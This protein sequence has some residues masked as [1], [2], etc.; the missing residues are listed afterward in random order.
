M[1]RLAGESRRIA[2]HIKLSPPGANDP[3]I[4]CY[5]EGRGEE[6]PLLLIPGLG[7][8][9]W[10]WRKLVPALPTGHRTLA[11][12]PRGQGRSASPAG[13]YTVAQMAEDLARLAGEVGMERPV[14]IG[15]G[16]GARCALLLAIER[17]A[18]PAGLVL[19]GAE[20]GP[21]AGEARRA[22]TERMECARRGDMNAAYRALKAEGGLP[23][24]MSPKE[25]A[26]HHR[27][28][29]TAD[30]AGH[31][32]CCAAELGAPDLAD[33]LEEV[34]CPALAIAG[35]LDE[36]RHPEAERLAEGVPGGEAVVVAGAGRFVQ[37][38]APE[39]LHTLLEEFLRKHSLSTPGK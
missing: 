5:E 1:V 35:E 39:A 38:E 6:T 20:T 28:F 29:L 22:L 12:E 4:L 14:L 23:R 25:R 18:L 24:G 32:A 34:A 37:L 17:P 9:V 27:I 21:P 31:A 8:T 36:T 15:H 2:R 7:D 10:S 26:E 30:P 13:P 3:V 16:L 33:R 19:L 11:V